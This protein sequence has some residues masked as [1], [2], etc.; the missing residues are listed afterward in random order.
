MFM[1]TVLKHLFWASSGCH[2]DRIA[3]PLLWVVF[4]CLLT[5]PF[6]SDGS[7]SISNELLYGQSKERKV[8]EGKVDHW[9]VGAQM[10]STFPWSKWSWGLSSEHYWFTELASCFCIYFNIFD[11][12]RRDAQLIEHDQCSFCKV[13]VD[14]LQNQWTH[15][16]TKGKSSSLCANKCKISIFSRK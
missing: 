2:Y 11:G 8:R 4:I 16:N 9:M 10:M 6:K 7:E 15:K 3:L 13:I 14:Y 5:L 1:G 12:T